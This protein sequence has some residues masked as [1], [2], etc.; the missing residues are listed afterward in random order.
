MSKILLFL[1]GAVVGMVYTHAVF[2]IPTEMDAYDICMQ[3]RK[4]I[5]GA[6]ERKCGEALDK[7]GLTFLCN[8]AGTVCWTER[9]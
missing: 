3:A 2:N 7:A 1:T 4:E 6:S 8:K 9:I 5:N